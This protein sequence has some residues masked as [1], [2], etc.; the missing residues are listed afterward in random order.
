[1]LTAKLERFFS[2]GVTTAVLNLVV[3]TG[4]AA[5]NANR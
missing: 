4:K 2:V 3:F 5:G 1:M